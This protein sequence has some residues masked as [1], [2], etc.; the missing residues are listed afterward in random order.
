MA[1]KP[2]KPEKPQKSGGA[3]LVE[4]GKK[5]ILLGPTK[6]EHEILKSAAEKE[7]RPVTQFLLFHGLKAAKKIL[8]KYS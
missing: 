5:P 7:G 3:R 2:E 1:K 6:S 4:S 8:S